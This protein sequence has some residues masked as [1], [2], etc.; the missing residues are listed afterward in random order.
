MAVN[1]SGIGVVLVSLVASVW[2]HGYMIDPPSRNACYKVFPG[3]CPP[4]FTPNEL[5]CGGRATQIGNSGKCGVCGDRYGTS[6]HVSPG[7]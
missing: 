7:K 2:G 5:N 3:K 6:R 4:N 1:L